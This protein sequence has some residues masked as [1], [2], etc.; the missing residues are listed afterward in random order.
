MMETTET[1]I[2]KPR[3]GA[4]DYAFPETN[5]FASARLR[6]SFRC[7][8]KLVRLKLMW[9]EIGAFEIGALEIGALEI[10]LEHDSHQTKT[11]VARENML[12]VRSEN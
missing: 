5:L 8:L 11:I 1:R 10:V 6:L 7:G 3:T 12:T 4:A 9:L 2:T